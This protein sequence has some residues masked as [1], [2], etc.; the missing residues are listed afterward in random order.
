MYLVKTKL[1]DVY[2]TPDCVKTRSVKRNQET[3]LRHMERGKYCSRVP[4]RSG[5]SDFTLSKPVANLVGI[6]ILTLMVAVGCGA[7]TIR[8]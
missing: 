3:Q 5:F 2:A 6:C 4:F 1:L 7:A 8:V